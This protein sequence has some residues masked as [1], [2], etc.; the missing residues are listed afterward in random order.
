MEF[1]NPSPEFERK[2]DVAI[3]IYGKPYQSAVTLLSL[4][5][6]CERWISTIFVSM[7]RRQPEYFDLASL[8][9]GVRLPIRWHHPRFW[10]GTRSIKPSWRLRFG[11]YRRS[12]R[13]QFAWETTR[14]PF[15]FVTHNDM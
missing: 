1:V 5:R 4:I 2:V 9:N 6:H 14:Q 7:D 12:L 13:Y 10:M 3:Q 8:L 15:L 11:P